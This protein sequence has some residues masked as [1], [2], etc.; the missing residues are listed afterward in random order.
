MVAAEIACHKHVTV[1][2]TVLHGD[3][4][5]LDVNTSHYREIIRNR[6]AHFI[7]LSPDQPVTLGD[8]RV[9]APS[10]EGYFPSEILYHLDGLILSGGGDVHPDQFGQQLAGAETDKI[11]RERDA[12]ELSLTKEAL[13]RDLP[14]F[15]I[16]RGC[17]ALNIAGGGGL[18]QHFDGHR[19]NGDATEFHDVIL[20]LGSR[21]QK[22]I[23]AKRIVVNT[24]HHQGINRQCIAP[25]FQATG[26]ADPDDWLVEAIESQH[27]SWVVGVQWHP[28][29][30]FELDA[31]HQRLWEQ[32][33]HA[34]EEYKS[35]ITK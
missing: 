27:H 9:F 1:G 8:G 23:N 12:F 13:Q 18:V 6:G 15:G 16:C 32:F 33:F 30:T 26:Y 14:I 22:A 11:C 31:A 4:V 28:E 29:R 7:A 20:V 21:V 24:F 2:V 25:G 19:S 3:Q 10:E 34:C 17:Q 5:W 35:R